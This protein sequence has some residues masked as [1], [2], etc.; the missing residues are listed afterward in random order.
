[1]FIFKGGMM[2]RLSFHAAMILIVIALATVG[3][4]D[5]LDVPREKIAEQPGGMVHRYLMQQVQDAVRQWQATYEQLK[6]PEQVAAYQRRV[7]QKCLEAIG[8]LPQRTPLAPQV[9][10]TVLRPGYRVEKVIFQSQ[11]RH[12]VTALLFL[13]A[14]PGFRPP[15]P[16]VIVP[17]GHFLASKGWP[18]YQTMGALLALNGMAALVF[19]P[20]DQGERGQY[21]GPDGWPNLWGCKA[22][23]MIGAGSIL[24]GRSTARFE[25]WDG[26]RA[27]DYLQ[28]RPEID[29]QRIGCTGNSGGGTQTS[30][31]MAL[32]DRIRCAAPSCYIT[33]TLQLMQTIGPD[34]AEQNLFGQFAGGPHEADW[35]LMR[36]PSPV[37]LCVA[38]KDFF[39]IG[40]SW[41]SF[42]HA[43]RLYT[44]L[45]LAERVDILENDA[46]HN[47]NSSQRQ[48]VVRWMSRWLLG[49]DQRITEP[50]ITLLTRKE[51]RCTTDGLVRTLPGAR[52]VYDLNEEYENELAKKRTQSW[53]NGDRMALLAEVRRLTGIRKLAELPKP[54]VETLDTLT[55]TG[56]RIEKLVITPEE[57]IALPALWFLPEKPQSGRVVLYLHQQGKAFDAAPGGPIERRVLAGETV[58]AVDVRGAG[59]TKSTSCGWN[60]PEV[61]DEFVAYMLGRCYLGMRAEDVLTCARYAAERVAGSR[62]QAVS[63]V[64]IGKVGVSALH[65][66]AL[67]PS[68]FERVTLS[69]TLV[70]WSNVIH[71]RLN[72]AVE[73]NLAHGVLLHYDLPNLAATLGSKLTI[74]QPVDPQGRIVPP[75]K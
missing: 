73:V 36:A 34:D 17:C 26:M 42:R 44:R 32:D 60:P 27:I 40:G 24:L 9:T 72:R 15:Y 16:G 19:D 13:P 7:R 50:P 66:A 57:G 43:K 64:A 2:P 5:E 8:G 71:N 63:L 51:F 30:Y 46:G 18:E 45:G 37:L 4:G 56:Y 25:I 58:L 38:T 21:S 6:T 31:L 39:D 52:S 11:R 53:A 75:E 20:I 54:R 14:A 59:Q 35:I 3:R 74:E 12:Y 41:D 65:A 55:R 29:P 33:S 62:G 70:S 47:Y 22:H 69:R 49:R 1:L 48:G 28:S 61:N 68:L 23:A 10:G 67:E